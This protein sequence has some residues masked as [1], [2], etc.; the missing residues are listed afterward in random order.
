MQ[1]Q[2][3][4]LNLFQISTTKSFQSFCFACCS[5]IIF[6]WIQIR[7][8]ICINIQCCGYIHSCE[9][10][11][12]QLQGAQLGFRVSHIGASDD[13]T[14]SKRVCL[15][16]PTSN[17]HRRKLPVMIGINA[18]KCRFRH[19]GALRGHFKNNYERIYARVIEWI[20]YEN[21]RSC[22]GIKDEA[23][24]YFR[25][26]TCQWRNNSK[27]REISELTKTQMENVNNLRHF[28]R[29]NNINVLEYYFGQF[30]A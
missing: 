20:W 24:S 17:R 9:H 21:T 26:C 18:L 29:S 10:K 23:E 14:Q 8:A 2:F 11:S 12:Y 1:I 30:V 4:S 13:E 15:R 27:G 25:T 6:H 3:G 19:R 5:N 7:K 16:T 22:G 28:N